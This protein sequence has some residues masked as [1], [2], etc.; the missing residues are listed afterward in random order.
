MSL[1]QLRKTVVVFPNDFLLF[2]VS[3]AQTTGAAAIVIRVNGKILYT[4]YYAHHAAFDKISP[5]VFLLSGIYDF[6]KANA[7]ELI[8]LGTSMQDDRIN[9]PLLQ[10]KKS[11][12][13][14]TSPKMIFE[15]ELS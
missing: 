13:G 1:L 15:K 14:E 7:C 6:A 11:V 4:F 3:D 12:G 10:F 9:Q 2:E 5:V 8:D